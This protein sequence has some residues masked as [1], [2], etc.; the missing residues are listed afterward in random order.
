MGHE[1]HCV[2]PREPGG[3]KSAL[4]LGP[5]SDGPEDID[6]GT[7]SEERS[8]GSEGPS[9]YRL[10]YSVT[11]NRGPSWTHANFPSTKNPTGQSKS[12]ARDPISDSVWFML[13]SGSRG[14]GNRMGRADRAVCSVAL[15]SLLRGND[16]GS[17]ASEFET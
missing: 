3:K 2:K 17:V 13:R 14:V 15:W 16:V 12:R 9:W 11:L 7:E 4:G 5:D 10:R 6:H 1:N 8:H